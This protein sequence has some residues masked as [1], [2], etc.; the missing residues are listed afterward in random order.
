[1]Y[2][3]ATGEQSKMFTLR[4]QEDRKL[5]NADGVGFLATV[6]VYITNLST[7]SDQAVKRAAELGFTVGSPTFTLEEIQRKTAAESATRQAL[8]EARITEE[9]AA[10]RAR[11]LETIQ[12]IM[13]G[14]M[15]F[16]K[17]TRDTFETICEYDPSYALYWMECDPTDN[18]VTTAIQTMIHLTDPSIRRLIEMR[19]GNDEWLVATVK[20]RIKG[21]AATV[22]AYFGFDG[23]YGWV[24]VVHYVLDNGV[25]LVYMGSSGLALDVGQKVTID[26]TVKGFDD[27][28]GVKQTKIIRVKLSK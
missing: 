16:G 10:A 27:Y 28:Q 15:P 7:N 22:T 3:I 20:E 14:V 11:E 18:N 12:T 23:A 5:F 8:I 13:G 4:H 24:D 2:Y 19:G 25:L 6:D 9:K 21:A 1:M 26:F 17:H